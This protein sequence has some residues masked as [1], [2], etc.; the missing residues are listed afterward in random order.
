MRP[1]QTLEEF[2]TFLAERLL[3]LEAIVIGGAALELLGIVS[4]ATRDCDILH[5]ALPP[6]I[7]AAARDFAR[8]RSAQ[9]EVLES[10]WLNNG[11][12]QLTQVLPGGWELR[13]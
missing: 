12:E 2:D 5:P 3:T 8:E 13:T 4:R 1:R 9:G 7:L 10:D 11:P 6:A